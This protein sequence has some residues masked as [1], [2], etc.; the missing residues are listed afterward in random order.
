MQNVVITRGQRAARRRSRNLEERIFV[1]FPSLYRRQARGFSRLRPRSRLRR[2]LLRRARVSGWS[3]IN[4]RDLE[5]RRVMFAPDVETEL[6]HDEQA[7]GLSGLQGHT[8]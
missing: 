8:A 2:M 4:R 6:A 5:F 1:R 7:L 3:A